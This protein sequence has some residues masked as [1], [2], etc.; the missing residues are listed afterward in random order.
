MLTG[1]SDSTT[2][3]TEFLEVKMTSYDVVTIC[4]SLESK[5]ASQEEKH[6]MKNDT[7]LPLQ[8]Y[9][10]DTIAKDNSYCTLQSCLQVPTTT[11][12]SMEGNTFPSEL[13]SEESV[14]PVP[15]SA[16]SI[17]MSDGY[18]ENTD[19]CVSTSTNTTGV[20]VCSNPPEE[21]FVDE[22]EQSTEPNLQ[23]DGESLCMSPDVFSRQN[24]CSS[25]ISRYSDFQTSRSPCMDSLQATFDPESND[26]QITM[27]G[28]VQ[29]QVFDDYIQSEHP[30]GTFGHNLN[31]NN[32]LSLTEYGH[33][34]Q[35]SAV[36]TDD[37][38]DYRGFQCD[39]N[40]SGYITSDSNLCKS[41][42]QPTAYKTHATDPSSLNYQ[43]LHANTMASDYI[44]SQ[45]YLDPPSYPLQSERQNSKQSML[46]IAEYC[47]N[48]DEWASLESLPTM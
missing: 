17:I 30:S 31:S 9:V 4:S 18:I 26:W 35:C 1:F 14:S 37:P 47:Y 44:D 48:I 46:S 11:L 23:S 39:A 28:S 12:P 13:E 7:K 15:L 25:Q 3:N 45:H 2:Q 40:M 6:Q 27:F 38:M 43:P 42:Q 24:D 5:E 16:K 29:L 8:G 22:L 20:P 32:E 41:A 36:Y 19:I 21:V 10:V 34:A 33:A